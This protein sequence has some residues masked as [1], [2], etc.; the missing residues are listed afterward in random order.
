M[1]TTRRP[2]DGAL[3]D[4]E[5]LKFRIIELQAL[6]IG[7]LRRESPSRGPEPPTPR[8]PPPDFEGAELSPVLA[9]RIGGTARL[10]C[11]ARDLHEFLGARRD[12]STWLKDRI[13]EYGFAEGE[14]HCTVDSPNSGNRADRFFDRTLG[15]GTCRFVAAEPP[16]EA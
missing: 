2:R 6:V 10:A 7:L 13:A 14:D 4:L 5:D 12:F 3:T 8:A 11:N 16:E 1:T 15:P 9:A